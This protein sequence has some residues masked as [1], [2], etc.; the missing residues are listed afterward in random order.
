MTS[1]KMC[2]YF[3]YTDVKSVAQSSVLVTWLH[4]G[5]TQSS[6]AGPSGCVK[7]NVCWLTLCRV[8]LSPVE[9]WWCPSLTSFLLTWCWCRPASMLWKDILRHWGA[10]KSQPSVRF[11]QSILH[12][13]SDISHIDIVFDLF[14]CLRSW[15]M[16]T[17]LVFI[18]GLLEVHLIL[19]LTF[20]YLN[21]L[22]V[23]KMDQKSLVPVC[24]VY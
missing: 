17:W 16:C 18:S 12:Q 4:W 20:S 23:I 22:L 19:I 6:M 1:V 24:R 11:S 21:Y 7:Y 13:H 3:S 15:T 8:L 14:V 10:T 9:L 2:V 5:S